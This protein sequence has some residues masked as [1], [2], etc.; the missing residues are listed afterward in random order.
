M[1]RRVHG[2]V[3]RSTGQRDYAVIASFDFLTEDKIKNTRNLDKTDW[4]RWRET[5]EDSLE[6]A[7]NDIEQ[8]STGEHLWEITLKCIQQA[9]K[10]TIPTKQVSKHSRLYFTDELKFLSETSV[11]PGNV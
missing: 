5:L 2:N 8:A 7:R 9:S 4:T 1:Y 3:H 11:G 10:E 6:E